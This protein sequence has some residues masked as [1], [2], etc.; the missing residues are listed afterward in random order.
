M[1]IQFNANNLLQGIEEQREQ[2]TEYISDSLERFDEHLT[3]I[4]VHLGDEN[5]SKEGAADKR[6]SLEARIEGKDPV[7][8]VHHADSYDYA[9]R[10]AV[11]KLE[12]LLDKMVE[13]MRNY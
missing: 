2:L 9:V 4:E 12:G 13:R 8:V 3:R 10:G 6:C 7:A 11:D 5:G 1:L